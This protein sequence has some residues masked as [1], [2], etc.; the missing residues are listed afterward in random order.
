MTY[1]PKEAY[2]KH[3]DKVGETYFQHMLFAMKMG[4]NCF[5]AGLM[6]FTH[7]I[8]PNWFEFGASKLITEMSGKLKRRLKDVK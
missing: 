7:A 2:E 8:L 3:W 1:P 5:K 4:L 6:A